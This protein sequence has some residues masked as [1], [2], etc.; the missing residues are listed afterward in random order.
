MNRYFI[1]FLILGL[2]A[3]AQTPGTPPSQ[4]AP[5]P[6]ADAQPAATSQAQV[7]P[8]ADPLSS[9]TPG[10][11]GF[12]S[13]TWES[14]FEDFRAV[15]GEPFSDDVVNPRSRYSCFNAE[16]GLDPVS[17]CAQFSSGKPIYVYVVAQAEYTGREKDAAFSDWNTLV[18]ASLGEGIPESAFQDE[19]TLIR[20]DWHLADD[21]KV[22]LDKSTD[23]LRLDFFSN[24][25]Q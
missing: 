18:E 15:F 4:E 25:P 24:R 1:F 10:A 6:A 7:D 11:F 20:I 21:T 12:A 13:L 22:R 16:I 2:A 9:L 14:S 5:Q 17:A 19:S 23:D 8:A 3:C